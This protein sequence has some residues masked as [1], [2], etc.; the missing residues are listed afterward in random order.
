MSHTYFIYEG[1]RVR[2][3]RDGWDRDYQSSH[4]PVCAVLASALLDIQGG[5][6]PT[7][8]LSL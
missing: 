3:L 5:K 2:N 7:D 8:V 6:D 1:T 4:E